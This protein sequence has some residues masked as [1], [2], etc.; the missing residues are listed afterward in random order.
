MSGPMQL[1][2]DG[3][4]EPALV[5]EDIETFEEWR[6]RVGEERAIIKAE[7][8]FSYLNYE[9]YRKDQRAKSKQ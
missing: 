8:P 1:M 2:A 4:W 7:P 6:A 3:T 9:E 5:G